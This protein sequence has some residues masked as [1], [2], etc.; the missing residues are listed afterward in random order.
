MKSFINIL[1]SMCFIL[2]TQ[3]QNITLPTTLDAYT[4]DHD[5]TG[6]RWEPN[7]GDIGTIS[8]DSSSLWFNQS[9]RYI[10]A[11]TV[12]YDATDTFAKLMIDSNS[13]H[14]CSDTWAGNAFGIKLYFDFYLDNNVI[15]MRSAPFAFGQTDTVCPD[16]HEYF[17][18][19]IWVADGFT[20]PESWWTWYDTKDD[21]TSAIAEISERSFSVY[22]N[23]VNDQLFIKAVGHTATLLDPNGRVVLQMNTNEHI[24]VM[25][26][27]RGVYVL[28][29][30]DQ[31]TKIVLE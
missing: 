24:N 7:L 17:T 2:S 5:I 20:V 29:S 10:G 19:Y 25:H 23:P 27:P 15:L 31:F 6:H 16:L 30:D 9:L 28:H 11:C 18:K 1:I 26:L 4:S 12:S 22:P 8:D 13:V 14:N 21:T 3:A